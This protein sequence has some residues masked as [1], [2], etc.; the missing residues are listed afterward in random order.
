MMV[1]EYEEMV[2]GHEKW[3]GWL[4]AGWVDL[5]RKNKGKGEMEMECSWC[6]DE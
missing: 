5:R 2:H 3:N 1:G 6:W 4:Y